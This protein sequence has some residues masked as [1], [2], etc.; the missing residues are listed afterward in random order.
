VKEPEYQLEDFV[1]DC[2]AGTSKIVIARGAMETARSDFKLATQDKVLEFIAN[3][4]LEKP[5]FINKKEWE[6]NTDNSVVIMVDAYA[7]FSGI[8]YGYIAFVYIKKTSRWLIKS[9]KKH[10]GPDPRNLV[11]LAA[12]GNFLEND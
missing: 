6:N 9:F 7:F 2:A 12:L 10:E 11:F 8:L 1:R 5:T 4:G 3:G